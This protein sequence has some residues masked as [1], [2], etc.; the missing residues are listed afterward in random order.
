MNAL[1][2]VSQLVAAAPPDKPQDTDTDI[3]T[4]TFLTLLITQ[5]RSQNPLDPMDPNEFVAQLA[6]FNSLS[7]LIEIKQLLAEANGAI[8]P[9]G[10]SAAP[11]PAGG[12][13]PGAPPLPGGIG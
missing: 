5:L 9:G 2:G 3:G 12:V 7:Q 1:S 13:S 8:K 4:N 10:D 11:A 6:Q